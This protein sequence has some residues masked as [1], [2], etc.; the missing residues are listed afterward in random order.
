MADDLDKEVILGN[1]FK[2]YAKFGNSKS[3]GKQITLTNIDKWLKEANIIDGKNVSTTDT[4][5][6][7]HRF[8]CKTIDFKQFLQ[9]LD[10]LAKENRLNIGNLKDKLSKI[11]A[12]NTSKATKV[13]KSNI[14]NRMTD[15]SKYTGSHKNRFDGTGK[16][17][18]KSGRED[19]S[20]NTGYVQGYKH[21]DTYGK[22]QA[23]LSRNN[24]L[25]TV[26]AK[27]NTQDK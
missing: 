14:V 26:P 3:D 1:I 18:G 9:F 19:L 25:S 6:L 7:F 24:K 22:K 21:K 15:T 13:D 11:G 23:Y 12:P 8:K 16:G 4:G 5:I 27:S 10:L 20:E 2:D 17:K